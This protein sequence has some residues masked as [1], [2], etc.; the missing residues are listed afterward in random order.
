MSNLIE[1]INKL[2]SENKSLKCENEKLKNKI[3]SILGILNE[4]INSNNTI[5]KIL[6]QSCSLSDIRSHK[7]KIGND[8]RTSAFVMTNIFKTQSLNTVLD[9]LNIKYDKMPSGKVIIMRSKESVIDSIY[10]FINKSTQSGMCCGSDINKLTFNI[11][12]EHIKYA[13]ISMKYFN[14]HSVG[15]ILNIVGVKYKK[16]KPN[17]KIEIQESIEYVKLKI[18]KYIESTKK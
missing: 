13:Q 16:L 14:T 11:C 3:N 8:Y 4:D 5:D 15:K 6:E 10:S 18:E 2:V 12:G 7:F 1:E 17:N 9:I